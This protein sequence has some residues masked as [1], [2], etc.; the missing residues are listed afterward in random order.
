[1]KTSHAILAIALT[2]ATIGGSAFAVSA[3]DTANRSSTTPANWPEIPAIYAKVK[4]AGFNDIYEIE[5]EHNG[6]EVKAIGPNGE[7]VKLLVDPVTGE[8]LQSRF[9]QDKYRG[10]RSD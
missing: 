5:R 8:V 6:Y 4:A 7:R 1:M 2:S 10:Y 3:N 9:K